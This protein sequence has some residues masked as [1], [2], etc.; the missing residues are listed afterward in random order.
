M[1]IIFG[2]RTYGKVDQVPGLFYVATKFFHIQFLPLIPTESFLIFD[3]TETDNNFRGCRIPL[4]GK[5]ILFA[6]ARFALFIAAVVAAILAIVE[7]VRIGEGRTNWLTLT[8]AGVS[9]V[10]S[11]WLFWASY[12]F[13]HASPIRALRIAQHAGI[14][15]EALAQFFVNAKGLP[16][17][18]DIQDALPADPGR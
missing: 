13:A 4:S 3:G 11:I 17:E 5:S 7:L 1:I 6:W 12:R 16:Q 8:I 14:P 2:N 15:P 18:E 10:A 9:A